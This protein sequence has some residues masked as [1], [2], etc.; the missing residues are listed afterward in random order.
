MARVI[1]GLLELNIKDR[2]DIPEF[3][4]TNP[5]PIHVIAL[6]IDWS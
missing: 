3:L 1:L 4:T 5:L 2:H 6:D